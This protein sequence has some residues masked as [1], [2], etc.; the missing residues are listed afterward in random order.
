MISQRDEKEEPSE[1][2][3]EGGSKAGRKYAII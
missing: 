3:E 1:M 2:S